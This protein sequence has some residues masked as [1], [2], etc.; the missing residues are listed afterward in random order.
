M[1]VCNWRISPLCRWYQDFG[2]SWKV[3]LSSVFD[4]AAALASDLDRL[5]YSSLKP[6]LL[7]IQERSFLEV[8][9]VV[10]FLTVFYYRGGAVAGLL[11][12]S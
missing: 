3:V 5:F 8:N 12:F 4:E 9:V 2:D 1:V 11:V 7:L 6:D 10:G